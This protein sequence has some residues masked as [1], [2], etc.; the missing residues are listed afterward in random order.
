MATSMDVEQTN[1]NTPKEKLKIDSNEFILRKRLPPKL[2]KRQNDIYINTKTDFN[3]QLQRCRKILDSGCDDV[4]IH[5][6]GAAVNR[7]INLALR[8]Q[9]LSQG[10]LELAVNTSTVELT[11]DIVGDGEITTRERNNSAVHIKIYKHEH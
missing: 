6:L 7:A 2:P 1:Q 4:T 11:D 9:E 5:G 8:V 3:A 10:S